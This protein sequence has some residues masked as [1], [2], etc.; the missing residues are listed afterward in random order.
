M[1]T[2]FAMIALWISNDLLSNML[3]Y[4]MKHNVLGIQTNTSFMRRKK[5]M[6]NF[7]QSEPEFLI[8]CLDRHSDWAVI[9]CLVGGGKKLILAKRESANGLNL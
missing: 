3:H 4:L 1:F 9:V 5:N 6:P 2:I 7:N 8:S